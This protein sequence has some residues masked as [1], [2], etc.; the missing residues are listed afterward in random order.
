MIK[1]LSSSTL[2]C[3]RGSFLSV[4][5]NYPLNPGLPKKYL[6]RCNIEIRGT[7][8][9]NKNSG[10]SGLGSEWNR[11]FPEFHSEILGV[12]REV[13]LKF[14]KIGITGKFCSIRPFLLGPSFY[15]PESNS[16]WRELL[17]LNNSARR[18]FMRQ[19]T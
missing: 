14:R 6:R 2:M 9:S 16:T 18:V 7:F 3:H 19:M 10:N 8:H 17:V 12:P 4:K 11:H 13:G 15:E 1:F 5:L